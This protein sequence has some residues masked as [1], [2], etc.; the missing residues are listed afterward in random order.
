MPMAVNT[1]MSGDHPSAALLYH[2]QVGTT[3]G[4]MVHQTRGGGA[5]QAPSPS[6]S[7]KLFRVSFH[8][9]L[10]QLSASDANSQNVFSKHVRAKLAFLKIFF[11]NI[12]SCS[13]MC[14]RPKCN[15]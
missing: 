8:D 4:V 1:T 14:T 9:N 2:V 13:L 15:A 10:E 5:T 6:P 7:Y 3:T 11:I 12:F